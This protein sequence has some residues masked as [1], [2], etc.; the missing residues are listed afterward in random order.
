MG[1]NVNISKIKYMLISAPERRRNLN[2][3]CIDVTMHSF[4]A[5]NKSRLLGNVVNNEGPLNA[6]IQIGNRAY[7]AI[8]L[9][10]IH[11]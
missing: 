6:T 9:S 2:N 4:D 7:Y 11:I 3:L 5:V 8:S 10:L 1:Q